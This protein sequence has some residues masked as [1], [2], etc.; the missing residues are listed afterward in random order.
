[1]QQIIQRLAVAASM[2][3]SLA[4]FGLEHQHFHIMPRARITRHRV[5]EEILKRQKDAPYH[6][7]QDCLFNFFYHACFGYKWFES[8]KQIIY[9]PCLLLAQATIKSFMP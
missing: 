8:L 5:F 9:T 4:W 6:S 1:V 7:A 2:V 3:L